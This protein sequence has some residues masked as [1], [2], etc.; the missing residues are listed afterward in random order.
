MLKVIIEGEDAITLGNLIGKHWADIFQAAG[1]PMSTDE[2]V[3]IRTK[4]GVLAY[5]QT[6]GFDGEP[7][8]TFTWVT[9]EEKLTGERICDLLVKRG[10]GFEVLTND[11][12]RVEAPT[13]PDFQESE[14]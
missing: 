14:L 10:P 11:K 8:H 9:N 1:I 6:E 13:Q 12:P 2:P 7:T 5:L 3:F 4:K